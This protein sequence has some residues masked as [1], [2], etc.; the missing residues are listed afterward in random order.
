MVF[1]IIHQEQ[2]Q[3]TFLQLNQST[4]GSLCIVPCAT[5]I[6]ISIG[7]ADL[8]PSGHHVK[9]T[10]LSVIHKEVGGEV[11]QSSS[12]WGNCEDSC[13]IVVPSMNEIHG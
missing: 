10:F 6:V 11:V 8:V 12:T 2:G 13:F 5:I 1:S 9:H 4:A 7:C 3:L